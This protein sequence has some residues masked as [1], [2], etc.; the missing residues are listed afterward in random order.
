MKQLNI[1]LADEAA[2]YVQ[3]VS[4]IGTLR[5]KYQEN[6]LKKYGW[7][8]SLFTWNYH[9]IVNQLYPSKKWEV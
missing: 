9:D 2:K 8:P 6:F 7:V 5:T 3:F 1:F 4:K